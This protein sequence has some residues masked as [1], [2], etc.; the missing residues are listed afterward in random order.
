VGRSLK[1][2]RAVTSAC[3][4]GV[5]SNFGVVQG[6]IWKDGTPRWEFKCKLHGTKALNTRGL[7]PRKLKDKDDKI[8]TDRQRNTMVE[9]EKDCGFNYLLSHKAVSRGSEEKKY[10]RTLKRLTH[11]HKLYLSP[12]PF[13]VQREIEGP[14]PALQG[15]LARNWLNYPFS[16]T[17]IRPP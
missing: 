12:F 5:C 10:V 14:G 11:T 13:K 9:V 15:R 3:K 7:E 1:E 6:R 16:P 17:I 2:W 4:A 8:V